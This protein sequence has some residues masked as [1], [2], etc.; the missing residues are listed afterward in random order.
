MRELKIKMHGYTAEEIF[1]TVLTIAKNEHTL[2]T[3]KNSE[4][5]LF[6]SLLQLGEFLRECFSAIM[7]LL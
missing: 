5:K 1:N 2:Y 4:K 7:I 6:F 3:Y